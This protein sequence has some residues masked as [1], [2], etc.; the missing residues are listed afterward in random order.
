MVWCRSFRRAAAAGDELK[1]DV[2]DQLLK[3]L[4]AGASSMS[5]SAP[6][7][8]AALAFEGP[9]RRCLLYVLVCTTV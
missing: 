7:C 3:V 8:V 5:L 9:E 1:S 4:S 6:L 2:V